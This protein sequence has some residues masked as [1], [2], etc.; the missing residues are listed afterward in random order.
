M[1]KGIYIAINYSYTINPQSKSSED[2]WSVTESV[3]FINSLKTKH[4]TGATLIVDVI[5]KTI[6]KTRNPDA[7]YDTVY[8]YVK[9]SHPQKIETLEQM[10]SQLKHLSDET[11]EKAVE[12]TSE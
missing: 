4:L 12:E 10:L 8:E 6:I 3:E 1:K 9:K 11:D 2:K 5:N 7:T